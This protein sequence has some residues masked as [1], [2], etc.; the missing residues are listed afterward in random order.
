MRTR[1]I[2]TV[3]VLAAAAI[4]ANDAAAQDEK[5]PLFTT[6]RLEARADFEV[7]RTTIYDHPWGQSESNE[8][9]ETPYGFRGKYFNLHAGGNMGDKLSYYFRQRINANAGNIRFFDNTDF[10]YFNYQPSKNWGLRFG[11][12]ALAVG[13]FEYD[14]PPIDILFN[15]YYWDMYYC[16]QLAASA[17][18]TSNDGNHT[19]RAQVANSPYHYYMSPWGENS[20]LG[21]SLMWTGN[22]GHF[23]TLYSANLFDSGKGMMRYVALGN[24]LQLDKWN[25]Y[26]DIIYR[27]IGGTDKGCYSAI[28]QIEYLPNDKWSLFVKG[29]YVKNED[30]H[31]TDCLSLPNQK[32]SY[33]GTGVF[34]RPFKNV[35]LHAF[36]AYYANEYNDYAFA[37][38]SGI[39]VK[40]EKTLRC[41][42]GATWNINILE[43][44]RKRM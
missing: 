27:N 44:M 26:L 11:K 37:S 15:G 8:T 19:L 22:M 12:D 24:M 14:A 43:A 38:L 17:A 25:A 4:S 7:D 18:W 29:S 32:E 16:F 23:K 2:L 1:S 35:R 42:I 21:Y 30:H 5:K 41:N 13:G 28:G 31:G 36:V 10:L 34:F 39:T 6:L 9:T 33:A 3:L 40:G 20:L